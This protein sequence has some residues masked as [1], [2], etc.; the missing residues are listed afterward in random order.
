[1]DHYH[2]L[3]SEKKKIVDDNFD[4]IYDSYKRKAFQLGYQGDLK[5]VKEKS[6]IL[7]YVKIIKK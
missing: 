5:F 6:N 4:D 7:I 3:G 1:M 2:K